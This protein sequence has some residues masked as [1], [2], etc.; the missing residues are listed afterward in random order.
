MSAD[1]GYNATQYAADRYKEV[2]DAYRKEYLIPQMIWQNLLSS[3]IGIY[4]YVKQ[5]EAIKKQIAIAERYV[6]IAEKYLRLAEDNYFK[7][8]VPTWERQRDLFDRYKTEFAHRENEYVGEAFR[9]KEYQPDHKLWEGRAIGLVQ[10]RFDRSIQQRM[11]QLGKYNR[12]RA[13][14]ES[15]QFAVLRGLATVDAMNHGFRYE[16]EKKRFLDQWFWARQTAG[17]KVVETMRGHVISGINGG[18]AGTNNAFGAVNAAVRNFGDA[19]ENLM[20]AW[21][22][23]ADFWGGIGNSAMK[24]AGYAQGRSLGMPF[25]FGG[26]TGS[27]GSHSFGQMSAGSMGNMLG[28]NNPGTV[29]M[30]GTYGVAPGSSAT[31]QG[32]GSAWADGGFFGTNSGG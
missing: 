4:A 1:Y 25:G 21:A 8:A 20:G 14:H 17:V 7:I 3:L 29:H 9:L 24:G 6:A 18:V 10:S 11:R 22:N 5:Y 13:C 15:L 26:T 23:M 12:G 31:W 19:T 2:N 32:D 27:G 16:E 28:H 30:P